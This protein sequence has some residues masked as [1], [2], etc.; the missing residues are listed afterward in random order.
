[1]SA[2][3]WRIRRRQGLS[4]IISP[5]GE[6]VCCA[7]PTMAERIIA[8]CNL[9]LEAERMRKALRSVLFAEPCRRCA[10]Q[11]C[12]PRAYNGRTKLP[13]ECDCH[14]H[15]DLAHAAAHNLLADVEANP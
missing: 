13:C 10:E 14:F 8:A 2:R 9:G 11:D 4:D 1:M 7:L 15:A 5:D 3:T 12:L 6:F